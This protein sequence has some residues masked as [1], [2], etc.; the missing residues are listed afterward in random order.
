MTQNDFIKKSKKI[1]IY[2]CKKANRFLIKLGLSLHINWEYDDWEYNDLSS[3][4]GVY[5]SGSVFE[6]DISIGFN[7]DNLFKSFNDEVSMFP[8]SNVD[9]ILSEI[10][11][12][13]VYHEMGHGIIEQIDDYLTETDELDDIYDQNSELFDYVLDN[14]EEAVESF[15]W[16]FYD[17]LLK[18]NELYEVIKLVYNI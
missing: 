4:I 6:K 12:T 11:Q 18:E 5:E 16:D 7:F 8:N 15:A 3:A 1:A 14:E 9:T 2:S 13:N 10:I 17:G